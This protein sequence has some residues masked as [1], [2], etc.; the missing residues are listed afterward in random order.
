MLSICFYKP[1][2]QIINHLVKKKDL[3]VCVGTQMT[4]SRRVVCTFQPRFRG[5]LPFVGIPVWLTPCVALCV[6][7][8][9]RP[10]QAHGSAHYPYLPSTAYAESCSV[11][12]WSATAST[13]SHFRCGRSVSTNQCGSVPDS[14]SPAGKFTVSGQADLV[15]LSTLKDSGSSLPSAWSSGRYVAPVS[16]SLG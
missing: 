11:A 15:H 7:P 1:T 13:A 4:Y 14:W 12:H 2:Q 16:R 8:P 6:F 3:N 10:A 5:G 9:V